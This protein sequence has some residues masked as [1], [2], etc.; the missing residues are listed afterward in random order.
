MNRYFY[1]DE[2]ERLSVCTPRSIHV[3]AHPVPFM[4]WHTQIHSCCGTPRSI[5]VVVLKT[6]VGSL[7]R[8]IVPPW[9]KYVCVITQIHVSCKYKY[10]KIRVNTSTTQSWKC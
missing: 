3:V 5:Y 10:Y 4:L 8:N 7:T 2:Q 1:E 9:L 6:N